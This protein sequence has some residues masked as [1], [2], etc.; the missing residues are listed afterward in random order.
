M[1]Q[2]L[3]GTTWPW[4]NGVP[5]FA[6]DEDVIQI[7]IGDILLTSLGERKMNTSH[8]SEVIRLVFENHGALMNAMAIREIT[9][10]LRFH[11]PLVKVVN[12]DISE[13]ARDNDPVDITVTYEYQ[14]IRQSTSLSVES[15]S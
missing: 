14:G 7:A 4:A 13:G 1:V 2:G 5:E 3:S 8:G 15:G 12:V 6:Y 11:L 9:A 10:S